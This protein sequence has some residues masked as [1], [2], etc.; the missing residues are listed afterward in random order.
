MRGVLHLSFFGHPHQDFTVFGGSFSEAQAMK[1]C[2]V[3]DLAL[4]GEVACHWLQSF[5]ESCLTNH[6]RPHMVDTAPSLCYTDTCQGGSAAVALPIDHSSDNALCYPE[7]VVVSLSS[8]S[9]SLLGQIPPLD[10]QPA[11]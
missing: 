7:L 5:R 1:V 10:D 6:A 4:Q 8:H 3:V 2:K 9:G 11:T